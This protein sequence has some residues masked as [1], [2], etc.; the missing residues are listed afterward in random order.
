MT[1]V[2]SEPASQDSLPPVA[3]SSKTR[4]VD[5]PADSGTKRSL[6]AG[7]G[8]IGLHVGILTF[9]LTLS[10][11]VTPP[12][13]SP[14]PSQLIDVEL[15]ETAPPLPSAPEPEQPPAPA[16][17]QPELAPPP[18]PPPAE[19]AP[20][21]PAPE[22]EPPPAPAEAGKVLTAEAPLLDASDTIIAGNAQQFAGGVTSAD[23]T[24]KA[25]VHNPAAR[26]GGVVGGRGTGA[27]VVVATPAPVIDRSR[28]P[29]LAGGAHWDCPFPAEADLEQIDQA[30]VS[31][32]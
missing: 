19:P 29:Q 14:E 12:V 26:S 30:A 9:A 28:S 22:Q 31:L 24:S 21:A 6:I 27:P 25:A 7:L 15:K 11:R 10:A 17:P 4:L 2:D 13:S 3:L 32:E 18:T 20:A 8:A 23:G 16:P 1:D 5:L